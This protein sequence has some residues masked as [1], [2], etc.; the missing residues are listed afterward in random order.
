LDKKR[1][2]HVAVV[3]GLLASSDAYGNDG[4]YGRFDGDLTLSLEV[5]VSETLSQS[6]EGE[7]IA[8]RAGASYLQTIG[9]YA[10]YNDSLGL[11]AVPMRRAISGGIEVKP[12]FLGRWSQ[13]LEQ[14][15]ALLDLWLDSFALGMGIY[16]AWLQPCQSCTDHG[17]ELSIGMELPLL[18]HASAPFIALRGAAR[19]SLVDGPSDFSR[20]PARALLTLAIGYHHLFATHIVDAADRLPR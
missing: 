14:G 18:A 5:G 20:P 7:S 11:R 2:G 10:Q 12:L 9:L 3:A 15:P 13:N 17:M 4:A 19:W 8:A 16:G 6:I 1:I